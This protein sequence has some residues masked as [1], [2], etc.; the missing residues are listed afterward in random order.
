[1]KTKNK[2]YL[3][4][5]CAMLFAGA[6]LYGC[7]K[8]D[9]ASSPLKKIS[10]ISY[11]SSGAPI[12][13][14]NYFKAM[15]PHDPNIR[16]VD[17]LIK[18]SESLI[19][20]AVISSYKT[21][22]KTLALTLKKNQSTLPNTIKNIKNINDLK[23]FL[24]LIGYG[25]QSETLIS[26]EKLRLKYMESFAKNNPE[27]LKLSKT[28]QVHLLIATNP[29]KHKKH[30][31]HKVFSKVQETGEDECSDMW[32]AAIDDASS[33]YD[34]AST[35]NWMDGMLCLATAGWDGVSI[36]GCVADYFGSQGG[37][38]GTFANQVNAITIQYYA[39]EDDE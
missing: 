9:S 32:E 8:K 19:K 20:N 25:A 7:M 37:D 5:P 24:N 31:Q 15:L 18:C 39:C 16:Q 27:F 3:V 17:S 13:D 6:I 35:K 33:A 36:A 22:D 4:L 12:R 28:E 21:K 26:Y 14:S 1:M 38:Y 2:Y 30:K 29:F 11:S 10:G 23:A 34:E